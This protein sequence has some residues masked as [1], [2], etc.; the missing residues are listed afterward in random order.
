MYEDEYDDTLDRPQD[1]LDKDKK[2]KK[3]KQSNS[4]DEEDDYENDE[5]NYLGKVKTWHEGS[6]EESK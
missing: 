5:V 2:E 3:K 6:D 1:L 4:S